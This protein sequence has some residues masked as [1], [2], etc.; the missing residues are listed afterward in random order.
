MSAF[1]MSNYI[2][3]ALNL[4]Q[5]RCQRFLD[6]PD[7]PWLTGTTHP[8]KNTILGHIFKLKGKQFPRHVGDIK[9]YWNDQMLYHAKQTYHADRLGTNTVYS[10]YP[11]REPLLWLLLQSQVVQQP[12]FYMWPG[13]C[14]DLGSTCAQ[15]RVTPVLLHAPWLV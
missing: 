9:H 11:T 1:E 4:I 15:A 6:T 7:S 8:T 13:S 3:P 5:I 12:W 10:A 14:N 2:Q